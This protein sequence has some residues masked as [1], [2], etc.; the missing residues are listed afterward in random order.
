MVRALRIITPEM[1]DTMLKMGQ[2]TEKGGF[3][4][5]G[6]TVYSRWPV[7]VREMRAD[8]VQMLVEL[9]TDAEREGL[10]KEEIGRRGRADG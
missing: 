2:F 6:E 3:S 8:I 4:P 9:L 1:R 7:R 5:K 10:F